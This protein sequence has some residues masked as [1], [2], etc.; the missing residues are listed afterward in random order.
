M[1]GDH[2]TL[3]KN[4]DYFIEGKPYLDGIEFRFLL[5][6][7]SRIDALQSGELNWSTPC[8]SSSWRP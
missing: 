8:R 6:D 4:D 3:E 1:Q 5:V 7:Q 2:V